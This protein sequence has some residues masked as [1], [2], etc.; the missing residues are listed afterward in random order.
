MFPD[1]EPWHPRAPLARFLF[2][3]LQLMIMICVIDKVD[4]LLNRMIIL[5]NSALPVV[6]NNTYNTAAP[7]CKIKRC[8][9][10]FKKMLTIEVH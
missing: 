1:G 10:Q 5:S 9:Q 3:E 4:G 2:V 7:S 8:V 6:I